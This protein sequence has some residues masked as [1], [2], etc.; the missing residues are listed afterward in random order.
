[1]PKHNRIPLTVLL[2][3]MWV[4]VFVMGVINLVLPVFIKALK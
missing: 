1:M 4:V 3:M 2:P